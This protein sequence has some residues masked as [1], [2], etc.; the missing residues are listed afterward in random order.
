MTKTVENT[1]VNEIFT[2]Q[3]NPW[4]TISALTYGGVCASHGNPD[5]SKDSVES[6]LTILMVQQ[7]QRQCLISIQ[8]NLD[9]MSRIFMTSMDIQSFVLQGEMQSDT[10]WFKWVIESKFEFATC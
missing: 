1:K 6:L 7:L 5:V 9:A 8:F 4:R 10:H 3:P 2:I